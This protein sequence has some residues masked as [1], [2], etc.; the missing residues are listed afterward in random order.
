MCSKSFLEPAQNSSKCSR[1]HADN[2]VTVWSSTRV[3]V[4]GRTETGSVERSCRI[5][6]KVPQVYKLS[7]GLPFRIYFYARQ[8]CLQHVARLEF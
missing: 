6:E 8:T 7:L 1:V 2:N 3:Q 4:S 5:L